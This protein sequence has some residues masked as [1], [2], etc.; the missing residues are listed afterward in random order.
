VKLPTAQPVPGIGGSTLPIAVRSV[1]AVSAPSPWPWVTLGIG[2]AALVTG[3]VLTWATSSERAKVEK[4][5]QYTDGTIKMTRS[6]AL[7]HQSNADTYET[8]SI[9]M[10]AVGGAAAV[11]GLVW[12]IVDVARPREAARAG[13]PGATPDLAARLGAF[14]VEGGAVV[15]LDIR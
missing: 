15:T 9:A 7:E 14:P 4:A 6:E 10:Y 2:A 12:G 13:R 5:S 3:G 8:A 11:A 1:P